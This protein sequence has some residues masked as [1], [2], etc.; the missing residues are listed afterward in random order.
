MLNIFTATVIFIAVIMQTSFLPNFFPTNMTPDLLLII[1]IIWTVRNGFN[2]VLTRAILA[3]VLMDFF[4]FGIVG[5]N[6][7]SFVMVVFL[8]DSLCKR[9]LVPQSDKKIF[10]LA[11][12]IALGIII[13]YVVLAIFM[14]ISVYLSQLSWQTIN[15]FSR[16]LALK[17]FYNLL[18]LIIIYWPI[19]KINNIFAQQ[20]KLVVK[21]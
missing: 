13:N 8:V 16:S 19:R 12:I 1:V 3:G 10:V 15:L 18:M 6:I 9:F 11:I 17:I 14:N 4:S 5:I 2:S 20:N 21:R 7:F